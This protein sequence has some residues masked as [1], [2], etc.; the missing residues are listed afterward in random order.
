[1][2]VLFVIITWLLEMFLNECTTIIE[3]QLIKNTVII[4]CSIY[5]RYSQHIKIKKQRKLIYTRQLAKY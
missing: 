5:V 1:M 2:W 4:S 3:N